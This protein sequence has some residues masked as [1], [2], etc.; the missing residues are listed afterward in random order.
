[1]TTYQTQV[2]IC[3]LCGT[4]NECSV[5][6]STDTIGSPDLDLR[7]AP[8]ERDTM[9]SWFQQCNSCNYVSVDLSRESNNARQIVASEEYQ[10]MIR[11][12]DLP[13]I[14]KRFALCALLNAHDRE[15]EG[16]ALLRAAWACDDED[17][18][19]AKHFRN[20]STET[21]LKLQ[22]FEDNEEQA[23]I[24]TTLVDVL[25]RAEQF[26]KAS[27]LASQM[28]KFKTVKRSAV[29]KSVIL[30]QLSLIEAK[31]TDCHKVDEA[32]GK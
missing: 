13:K 30:F 21:L 26:E 28:L 20:Q 31:S 15:I 16:T 19:Q 17:A 7:P 27:K 23:T 29:M 8:M 5:I 4:E 22:P 25:R 14:A 6:G 9:H 3:C 12:P 32:I 24:A 2:Q 11:K 18:E 10:E 1:M